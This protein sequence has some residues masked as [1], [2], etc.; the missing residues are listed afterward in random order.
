MGAA[1][2]GLTEKEDRECRIDQQD[3][4]DR[5]ARFLAALT[6]RLLN[7]IL[8]TLD[9]PLGPVVPKRGEA[10]AEAGAAAGG[11]DVLGGS[12]VGTTSAL[13]SPSV[14]PRRFANA[15]KDRV[16]ASPSARSVARRTTKST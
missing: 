14:T 4:F 6:A 9:A 5:V 3:V 12:A 1:G 16:G 7:W 13:A 15:V 10:G 2:I 11:P 8:G